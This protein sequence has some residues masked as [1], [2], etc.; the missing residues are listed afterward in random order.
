M[1]QA[2]DL[3][4]S[5]QNN[6]EPQYVDGRLKAIFFSSNDS[7]YKVV[8]VEITDTNIN[9]P[10]DEIVVTG[11]FGDLVEENSYHFMGKLVDHPR[12]GKQFQATN[13]SSLIAT[14]KEGVIKYLSGDRFPGVG[15]KTAER[16]V[17]ALGDDAIEKITAD[18]RVLDDVPISPKSRS[19]IID[20][21]DSDDGLEKVIVGLNSYGFSSAIASSIYQKYHEDALTIIANN[22]YQLVEDIDG[23]SFK[24]AD[25]IALKLGLV[26]DSDERIR[27]GLMYAIN[28]L[29]LKN[30]DT[31]TTT[32]PLIEMASSVLEGNS[33]QQ[34]SGKK[35]AASLVALAKEGKVIGEENRIYLTRLYNAEVQIA[36]HLNRVIKNK[37]DEDQ[38]KED[39]IKKQLRVVE[40]KFDI[41]YDDSQ[42]AAI[43]QA[44]QSPVFILTGGP[45]TG[46]TTIINGIVNTYARLHEY[47][48]DINAY[49][50]KPFPI[51]LAA[52]TGRAAKHMTESTGLPASTI[53]RLLGLNGRESNDVTG[54]KDIEGSLLIIDEMSM[55]DTYLFRSLVR[56]IPN[57]MQVVLVGDQDQ[58]PSVGPGQVFHDLLVSKQIPAMQLDTIYRQESGSSI[59]QLAHDIHSGHLSANFTDNQSDR[60]FIPCNEN[61]IGSVIEQVTNRARQKGFGL[62]DVQVLA[63]MYRGRA[64]IDRINDIVQN[65]WQDQK[66]SKK[67]VTIRDH[68]YRIGDKVLQLVNN[69]ER[70][71]FNGDLG[72]IVG[73]EAPKGQKS[74]NKITID[75]DE[76]EVT[77]ENNEWTQFTLAYCTSI[78]KAQGSEFK[79]VILP[80]VWQ[81]SRMLQRNLL[82]TAVTRA[83]DFLIMLGEKEA[84]E[85]CVKSVSVNRQT[86]LVKRLVDTIGVVG[87]KPADIGDPDDDLVQ[88]DDPSSAGSQ[89][90]G[91]PDHLTT[92][93][94]NQNVIDPMIGMADVSPKDFMKS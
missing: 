45:G 55:V 81:F 13:Y 18:S 85:Q 42:V 10:E 12:Y 91:L 80:I 92:D 24:R 16:V 82:Y 74:P 53:H 56:A 49:K 40:K 71:V 28:E 77:Y 9:W 48:L 27:A 41:N 68:T 72:I 79:M 89:A 52:P 38:L 78:H 31:Y 19:A 46:K 44:I 75:F 2:M 47:S 84:F 76:T 64:G 86:S 36:D 7:F 87:D 50:D 5:Q 39:A 21:L 88:A 29:C 30:G 70:N 65:V 1:D 22:P 94:I 15:K 8:L 34:I 35:L 17:D 23:I 60:S 54:T 33:E 3:F 37:D 69:P 61:Q 93:V 83:S 25:A 62:M 57:H 4:G 63:P 90:A 73:M 66:P 26:P 6:N 59:I 43:I 14:T 11:S 58:L 20:N 67:S 51:V 32:Q